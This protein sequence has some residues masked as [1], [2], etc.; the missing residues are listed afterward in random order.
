MASVVGAELR[1]PE[2]D[3]ALLREH[4]ARLARLL[5]D[6][7]AACGPVAWPRV[8]AVI[9]ALVELYGAGL[10]RLL[11]AARDLASS[12]GALDAV[13]VG[14]ELVSSLLLLHGLHPV[15]LE[16]RIRA[17]LER[18]RLEEPHA[19]PLAVVDVV[20][21]VVRL[22]VDDPSALFPPPPAHAV[23]RAIERE[24]PELMGIYIEPAGPP[25]NAGLVPAN[26]LVRG[27][28]R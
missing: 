15:P 23:A 11:A 25:R 10:E 6:A 1:G 26:H 17:A 13:L 21:G 18:L 28:K 3:A 12:A 8:E 16:R 9:A 2:A 14:D 19:A 7:E 22:R 4:D 5:A 27:T 24:A 20:D